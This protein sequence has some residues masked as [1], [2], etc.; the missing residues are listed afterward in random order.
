MRT[1]KTPGCVPCLPE[2]CGFRP[3]RSSS[4]ASSA[5][6]C[7]VSCS[8]RHGRAVAQSTAALPETGVPAPR[9]A[10]ARAGQE[11][12]REGRRRRRRWFV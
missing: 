6:T 11:F 7:R 10:R 4:A 2:V 8:C 1:R 9:T 12:P 5:G 3:S